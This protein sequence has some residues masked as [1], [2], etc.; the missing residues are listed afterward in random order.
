MREQSTQLLL[1]RLSDWLELYVKQDKLCQNLNFF[2]KWVQ[3][4]ADNPKGYR[5]GRVF[6]MMMIHLVVV[7][8]AVEPAEYKSGGRVCV[9]NS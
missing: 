5:A 2:F 9:A 7:D 6:L 1:I 3:Y 4:T 8:A